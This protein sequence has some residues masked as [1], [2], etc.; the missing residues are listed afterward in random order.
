MRIIGAR[1]DVEC[2]LLGKTQQIDPNFHCSVVTGSEKSKHN[3]QP[4]NSISIDFV[5]MN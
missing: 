2:M 4:H 3:P 5:Q 1:R